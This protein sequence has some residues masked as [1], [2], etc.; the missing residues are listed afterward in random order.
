[1]FTQIKKNEA[2]IP[3]TKSGD[4]EGHLFSLL[5]ATN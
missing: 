2:Q 1:M 5:F 4:L 3:I